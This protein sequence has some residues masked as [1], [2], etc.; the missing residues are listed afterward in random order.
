M[1]IQ[2]VTNFNSSQMQKN[3]MPFKTTTFKGYVN[4]KFYK[5]EIIQMAKKF[6]NKPNWEAEL[7]KGKQTLGEALSSWHHNIAPSDSKPNVFRFFMGIYTL[8]ISEILMGGI[9]TV[10]TA[11]SNNKIENDIDDIANC[12][13]DLGKE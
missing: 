12:I 4:G 5:D 10:E 11:I 13:K 2:A 6:K 8:G 3:N 9:T 7:R 1:K